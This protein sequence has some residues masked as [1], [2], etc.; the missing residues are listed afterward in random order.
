MNYV[1]KKTES[2]PIISDEFRKPVNGPLLLPRETSGGWFIRKGNES[3][4]IESP[5]RVGDIIEFGF[6][7]TKHKSNIFKGPHPFYSH[8]VPYA[9]C[10]INGRDAYISIHLFQKSPI[11][12][13]K[14]CP[15]LQHLRNKSVVD[16]ALYLHRKKFKIKSSTLYPCAKFDEIGRRIGQTMCK[17][18][19]FVHYK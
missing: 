3:H 9:C 7:L 4:L 11:I 19:Y 16:V 14:F 15:I 5:L 18:P 1:I 13:A 12:K 8:D 10:K 2:L 6:V 17:M